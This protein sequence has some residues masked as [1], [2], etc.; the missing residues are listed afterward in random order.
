MTVFRRKLIIGVFTAAG[1]GAMLLS[2]CT[3]GDG[4]T[5][6]DEVVAT[7]NSNQTPGSVG[8][9]RETDAADPLDDFSEETSAPAQPLQFPSCD[10]MN[11]FLQELH[12]EAVPKYP[13]MDPSGET[14]LEWFEMFAGPV[15]QDAMKNAL[16]Y[17]GCYYP[18]YLEYAGFEW[19]AELPASDLESL[20]ESLESDSSISNYVFG[21]AKVFDYRVML[22]DGPQSEAQITYVFIDDIWIAV[23]NGLPSG[24]LTAEDIQRLID[25]LLAVNPSL[26]VSL[27][28]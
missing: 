27:G 28:L 18:V 17:R 3:S 2:G 9:E 20:V 10:T 5:S 19:I 7:E 11:P 25:P 4:S 22:Q 21:D 14:G 24:D 8:Q 6:A 15:A 23:F 1:V 12:E 13:T 26:E 16:Q